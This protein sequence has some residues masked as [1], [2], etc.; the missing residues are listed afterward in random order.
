MARVFISCN[1]HDFVVGKKLEEA[2]RKLGHVMT[3]P[4]DAK[5]AGRWEEQ[6]LHGLHT[7]D[8]FICLLTPAGMASSWVLAQTG[9]A[10]SREYTK[11]MLV[12]PV[13]PKDK[14]PNFV[15]A[16]HCFW[17]AGDD[18]VAIKRLAVN[19]NKAIVT[20]RAAQPPRIFL[21]HRHKDAKVARKVID[22][23]KSAFHVELRD[24]RCTSVPGYR[25]AVGSQSADSLQT[26]L[27]G[28]EI[29]M[30][31]I[32]PDTSESDYVLFELGASWGLRKPTFPLRIAGATFKHLPEVLREKSSL[33]LED[34]TQCLQLVEDV[35]RASSIARKKSSATGKGAAAVRRH[36]EQ[37]AR[38][39]KARPV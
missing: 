36:A 7:A 20:H 13:C 10:I 11:N 39:A 3:L 5:P 9:M 37:L 23:L 28:A 1:N 29:V 24:V 32:G 17:L 38:V 27:R 18:R 31:L 14:I 16:F 15:A 33:L 21:S 2:L 30:G 6:L 22:L 34:V 4:V 35:D 19:L 25:L 8:A 12:L 26:D